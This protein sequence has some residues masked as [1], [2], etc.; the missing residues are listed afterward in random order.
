MLLLFLDMHPT[1]DETEDETEDGIEDGIEDET[2]QDTEAENS[3]IQIHQCSVAKHTSNNTVSSLAEKNS[4]SGNQDEWDVSGRAQ[5]IDQ[6]AINIIVQNFK[7]TEIEEEEEENVPS[8]PKQREGKLS[9]ERLL[10]RQHSVH[11][12]Y[13]YKKESRVNTRLGNMDGDWGCEMKDCLE[14]DDDSLGVDDDTF[15]TL[16]RTRKSNKHCSAA[17]CCDCSALA[18]NFSDACPS[19]LVACSMC[20]CFLVIM[21][22][23]CMLF[24][25]IQQKYMSL[26]SR[27]KMMEELMMV[28]NAPSSNSSL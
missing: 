1:E 15:D 9:K 20:I 25:S 6:D 11:G 2:R 18:Q 27:L 22:I 7:N 12:V 26:D 16:R 17:S 23:L 8:I 21:S 24:V 28:E 14:E 3:T 19:H 5:Q 10:A 13:K 4:K